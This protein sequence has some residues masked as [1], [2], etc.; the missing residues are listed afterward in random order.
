VKKYSSAIKCLRLKFKAHAA[1]GS[2]IRATI[3]SLKWRDTPEAQDALRT[4]REAKRAGGRRT[5]GKRLLKP[6]RRPETGDE[7]YAL[8]NDKRSVGCDARYCLLA[9]GFLKG[10]PYRSI[11]PE[12]SSP[13]PYTYKHLHRLIQE[14][15]GDQA[16]LKAELTE[17]RIADW[18]NGTAKQEAA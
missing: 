5:I 13:L 10:R 4:V 18:L 7:R 15:L 16:D 3:S 8:W 14:A 12:G 1:E 11:E 17:Q 6:Y 9:M 2:S